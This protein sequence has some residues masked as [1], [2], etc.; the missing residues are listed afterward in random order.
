MLLTGSSHSVTEC[1]NTGAQQVCGLVS[2]TVPSSPLRNGQRFSAISYVTWKEEAA[3]T[4]KALSL[5]VSLSTSENVFPR[6]D[7][8]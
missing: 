8:V 3:D 7:L 1:P 5:S 4:A 6:C 2:G